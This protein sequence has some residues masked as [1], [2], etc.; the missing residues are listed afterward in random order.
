M[1]RRDPALAAL[2]T[3]VKQQVLAATLLHPDRDWYLGEL[4]RHL[5]IPVS[6]IQHEL[7]VFVAAGLLTRRRDGNRVYYRADRRCP[8]FPDLS[9]ILEK[10]AGV[11]DTLKETLAPLAS[12]IELA[13]IYG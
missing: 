11:A 4:A 12:Q 13:F 9:R 10:T 7:G 1:V 2:L 3:T 5:A 6:T 8:I